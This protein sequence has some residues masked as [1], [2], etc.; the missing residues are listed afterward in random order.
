MNGP[1]RRR[2][3]ALRTL[4]AEIYGYDV[5]Y[6]K[7]PAEHRF[8]KGESG[9]PRGRPKGS[10]NRRPRLNEEGLKEIILAEAYRTI[11][12]REGDRMISYPIAQA[13]VRSLA[14]KAVQGSAR[15]QELFTELLAATESA[16]KKL[17]DEFFESA[18]TY[19]VEWQRE[20]EERERTGR[21]GPEP[22]PHPDDVVIDMETGLVRFKGPVTREEK[23]KWDSLREKKEEFKEEVR[24]LTAEISNESD[25]RVRK[26][27]DDDR[28][29]YQKLVDMIHKVIKD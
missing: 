21:S 20:L 15:A 28:N 9:N 10:K 2:T 16:N 12:L 25:P 4:P 5:G 23:A 22:L 18:V 11:D 19:K 26:I 24:L 27:M 7:P 13:V 1:R 3:K 14:I 17:C 8:R 6:A 29:H